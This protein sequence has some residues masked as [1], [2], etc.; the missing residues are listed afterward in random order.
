MRITLSV[1]LFYVWLTATAALLEGIGWLESIGVTSTAGAGDT[2]SDGIAE[3]ND[4]E[5]G[6]LAVESL[7]SIYLVLTTTVESFL[8]A[9]TAGPRIML[10]LGVPL[11]FV[12]F[13]H[14]PLALLAGRFLI[15]MLSG[16]EA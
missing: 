10:N 7:I 14:A 4:I 9:L 8:Q 12:A 1:V 16:R 5:A 6:N 3:L 13:V 11:E 2:L 15:F